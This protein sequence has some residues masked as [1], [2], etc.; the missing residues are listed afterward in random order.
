MSNETVAGAVSG[1]QYSPASA[2][3]NSGVDQA[4]FWVFLV[5]LALALVGAG[6]SQIENRGGMLW[7]YW[8]GLI[9]IYAGTSIVRAWFKAQR[10]ARPVWPMMRTA[11]LR[12]LG[13]VATISI[14]LLFEATGITD[15]GPASVWSRLVLA[16]SSYLAGVY[17][18]WTFMLLGGILA[19]IA[20]A[21][22]FL[23]QLSLLM[24]VLPLALVAIVLVFTRKFAGIVGATALA[25]ARR[26]SVIIRKSVKQL[27]P[28]LFSS[29]LP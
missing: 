8:F 5:L 28:L 29:S 25:D 23:D 18:D 6:V 16:L 27:T 22:G 11:V 3:L 2:D 4:D 24:V 21:L 7:L 9:L 26:G 15:R 10:Q 20:V 14:I 13:S 1:N 17:F 12:W 19:I